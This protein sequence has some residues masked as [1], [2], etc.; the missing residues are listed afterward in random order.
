MLT[1]IYRQVNDNGILFCNPQNYRNSPLG[2]VADFTIFNA[3]KN[4]KNEI[5][6]YMTLPIEQM[7]ILE[8]K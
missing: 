6:N 1:I 7:I 3:P 5:G 4:L 8:V 2:R